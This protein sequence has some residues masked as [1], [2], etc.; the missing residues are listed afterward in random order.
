MRASRS[1]GS[2]EEVWLPHPEEAWARGIVT[3]AEEDGDSL[4]VK[5]NSGG[6]PV[7]VASSKCHRFDPSHEA[8]LM[9][10]AKMNKL[11]EGKPLSCCSA[12]WKSP[13]HRPLSAYKGPLL[14]AL[15]RRY[16]QDDIYTFSTEIVI[17]LNP[18]KVIEELDDIE[19]FISKL[20]A[21]EIAAEERERKREQA[22]VAKGKGGVGASTPSSLSLFSSESQSDGIPPHVYT[23][24]DR[25]FSQMM[26]RKKD[27]SVIVS[28]ESGAGKTESC[29]RVMAYLAHLSTDGGKQA[30]GQQAG[31]GMSDTEQR[32]L[33]C[34][35]FLEAFGNAKT[36]RNNNS[37]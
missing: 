27:Q 15:R 14:D 1:I 19:Q 3:R 2:G 31:A 11:H 18:Y 16:L 28:G 25:S 9:D 17:S 29:K 22:K 36:G 4:Q 37:R 20:E 23:V 34:N 5:L 10:I 8:Y 24:A 30:G 35:P 33:E 6:D 21:A 26:S 13:S 7:S 12:V 32:V